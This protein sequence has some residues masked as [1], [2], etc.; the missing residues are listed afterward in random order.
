MKHS[1]FARSSPF[2]WLEF[3]LTILPRRRSRFTLPH[4]HGLPMGFAAACFN[5]R[6]GPVCVGGCR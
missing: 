2:R 4:N 3:T 6:I 5:R 1:I